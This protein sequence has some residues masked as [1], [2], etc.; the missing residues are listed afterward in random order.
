MAEEYI[1]WLDVPMDDL[2]PMWICPGR[3]ES[4]MDERKCLGKV[5][6]NLPNESLRKFQIAVGDVRMWMN[7]RIKV[8]A[9][10]I[11]EQEVLAGKE[12]WLPR[13]RGNESRVI[14]AAMNTSKN[15]MFTNE[16]KFVFACFSDEVL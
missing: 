3:F 10:T 7:Q 11:F 1:R 6:H 14:M 16:P 2:C 15:V 5:Q 12:I 9:L 8:A 13:F 4:V